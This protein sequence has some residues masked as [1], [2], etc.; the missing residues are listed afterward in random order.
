MRRLL[1]LFLAIAALLIAA[2]SA[3]PVR[4]QGSSYNTN[5]ITSITYQNVGT[6]MAT[7]TFTFYPTSGSPI[8]FNRTLAANAG[9]SLYVGDTSELSG[10]SGQ[11][12]AVISSDQPIVA[13]IVQIPQSTSVR[14]RPLSNGFGSNDGSNN[15]LI[16]TVLKNKFN[17][18]QTT[19]FSIQNAD[20]TS[21]DVT[22]RFFEVGSA[23]P[24][25]TD[26]FSLNVGTARFFDAGT[27]GGLGTSFNGS[28]VIQAS[29]K[30]VATAIEASTN[31]KVSAFEGVAQGSNTIYMPSA[32]CNFG[33]TLQSTAYAVQNTSTSNSANVTVTY[34]NLNNNTVATVTDTILPGSKKSFL[35]CDVISGSFN[36][37]ATIT[38]T[39]A[40]IVAIGKVYSASYP[41]LGTA[42]VGASAGASKLA[43]P[44]VRWTETRFDTNAGNR[45]R[46]FIAIQ[47]VGTGSYRGLSPSNTTVWMVP[48]LV[49]IPLSLSVLVR[50][51]TQSR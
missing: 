40:P 4:A 11:G 30:V 28:A 10:F 32:L 25:Y 26:T 5:F 20:S 24:I 15:V 46:A 42:F 2:H 6:A 33:T 23:T 31:P 18:P 22:L 43:A 38:S 45:Q 37:S 35:T 19:K 44:Y 27:I 41:A 16:A 21:V 1:N 29:G 17:P 48:S 8:S 9:A 39:G 13:T 7:I 36:G 3:I 34:K 12:S 49:L 14:N 50:R 47:N 51:R